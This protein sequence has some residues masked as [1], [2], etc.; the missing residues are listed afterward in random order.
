MV[1]TRS[2]Q[3]LLDELSTVE[4]RLRR[5]SGEAE[6]RRILVQLNAMRNE[7]RTQSKLVR[8]RYFFL[9]GVLYAKTGRNHQSGFLGSSGEVLVYALE[10]FNDAIDA[11]KAAMHEHGRTTELEELQRRCTYEGMAVIT[12]LKAWGR[13]L[14]SLPWPDTNVLDRPTQRKLQNAISHG[15]L[16]PSRF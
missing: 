13:D 1:A 7:A 14:S 12:V 9:R 10:L 5:T 15:H 8:A 2:D 3:N 6:L 11:T 16:M 4:F